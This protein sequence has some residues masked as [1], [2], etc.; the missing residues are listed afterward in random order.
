MT[1]TFSTL[2]TLFIG[3]TISYAQDFKEGKISKEELSQTVHPKDS[4]A[5]AA[6][7]HEEAYLSMRYDEQWYYDMEVVKRI[8]IYDQ[9]GYDYATITIPYYYGKTND[10]R[11]N[12]KNIKAYTYNLDGNK[13][14][15]EKVK[16]SDIVDEQ[17][18]E[19]WKQVKFTFPNL[20]PGSVIEYSYR[21][22]SPNYQELPEWTFQ[23]DIPVNYSR[24]THV[25]PYRFG[26]SAYSR[27]YHPI[28]QDKEVTKTNVNF[29]QSQTDFNYGGTIKQS[30]ETGTMEMEA[31]KTTYIA[32]NV[33]KLKDEPFVNNHKNFMTSVR[34][35]IAFTKNSDGQ[36]R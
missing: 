32:V 14:K 30:T 29:S 8:K 18:S 7:L 5:V 6:V 35:E 4:S 31:N 24:Y 26:Y 3:L 33:P 2:I 1:K 9:E 13:I 20:K 23:E 16:K 27:G 21:Y 10:S 12:V 11:E 17:V 22:E 15:D 25:I 36:V 19:Y 28:S 34:H